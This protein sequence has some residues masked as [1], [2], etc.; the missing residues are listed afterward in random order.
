MS[1]VIIFSEH[2]VLFHLLMAFFLEAVQQAWRN[3]LTTGLYYQHIALSM[4]QMT[5]CFQENGPQINFLH[6]IS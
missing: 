6:V 5:S 2:L 3:K 1:S 4:K